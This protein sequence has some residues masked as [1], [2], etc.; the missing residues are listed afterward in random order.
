[1]KKFTLLVVATLFA[2]I[3]FAQKPVQNQLTLQPAGIANLINTTSRLQVKSDAETQLSFNNT[4]TS[5]LTGIE[6]QKKKGPRRKGP[7]SIDDILGSYV[8]N[9]ES[10]WDQGVKINTIVTISA[11]SDDNTVI[12]SD[13]W[14]SGTEDLTATVDLEEGTLSLA[15]GQALYNYN[16]TTI[17]FVDATGSDAIIGYVDGNIIDFSSSLWGAKTNSGYYEAG[18]NTLLKKLNGKLT[19]GDSSYDVAITQSEDGETVTV[20]NFGMWGASVTITLN[21]DGTFTIPVQQVYVDDEDKTYYVFGTDGESLFEIT[22][23]VSDTKLTFDTDWTAFDTENN[24]WFGQLAAATIELTDGSTFSLPIP[25]VAA[26]PADPTVLGFS[27]YDASQGYGSV[28]FVIPTED[29]DGNALLTSQLYYEMYT[30]VEG[31]IEPYE[32]ASPTYEYVTD[33]MT[34]VPYGYIDTGSGYDFVDKGTYKIIFLNFETESLNRIGFK[35]IYTGGDEE[36]ESEISWYTI[37]PYAVT[38]TAKSVDSKNYYATYFEG[39]NS[40][41]ADENTTVYTAA[42]SENQKWL[43]LTEVEDKVIP[44]GNAVVLLSSNE[45]IT[46]TYTDAEAT[47]L[48][49]NVL[50]GSDESQSVNPSTYYV[51]SAKNGVVGFYLFAGTELGANKAYIPAEVVSSEARVLTFGDVTDAI[52]QMENEQVTEDAAVYDLSGRRIA[53]RQLNKGVYINN[54][55]KIVIK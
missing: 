7:I 21:S 17:N 51:L 53:N 24:S 10:Y 13:W 35:S 33:A 14:F 42:L 16:G 55:K 38:L 23:Q 45:T 15:S 41:V 28:Y 34:I 6:T 22:G 26:V 5:R 47:T 48:A 25:N 29:V 27:P 1:M 39:E 9:Y 18:L 49:N 31:V 4:K 2:A 32:F 19:Y 43:T 3:S 50:Q 20:D 44:A 52:Q 40:R 37:K 8:L 11:G 30:D 36:N 46:L 12:I 54:G